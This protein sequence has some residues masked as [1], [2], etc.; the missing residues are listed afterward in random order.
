M[1]SGDFCAVR[2]PRLS[3]PSPGVT[4]RPR[5]VSPDGL[6]VS[7]TTEGGDTRE[8]DFSGIDA[9]PGLMGPLVAAFAEVSGPAGTW[10]QMAS[11]DAGWKDATSFPEIHR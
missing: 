6:R 7:V 11:V 4:S 3:H 2:E 9:P 1:Y 8:F 10:R 5:L